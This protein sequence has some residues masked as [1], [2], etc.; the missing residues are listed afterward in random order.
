MT[1]ASQACR[2]DSILNSAKLL[3]EVVVISQSCTLE[4]PDTVI[5]EPGCKTSRDCAETILSEEFRIN[6]ARII[7]RKN[8]DFHFIVI[9]L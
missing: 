2:R 9:F 8:L 4:V 1:E 7:L 6:T 5:V 3:G